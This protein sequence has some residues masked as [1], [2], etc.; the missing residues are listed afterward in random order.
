M[1]IKTSV[2]A[3]SRTGPIP[4]HVYTLPVVR[5]LPDQSPGPLEARSPW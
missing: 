1:A 2:P 3:Q 5:E 4:E